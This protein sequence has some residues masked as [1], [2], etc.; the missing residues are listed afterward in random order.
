VVEEW[1][2]PDDRIQA[3]LA[4]CRLVLGGT[5]K[6]LPNKETSKLRFSPKT[7]H[8]PACKKNESRGGRY[9]RDRG[10]PSYAIFPTEYKVHASSLSAIEHSNRN[11]LNV[12]VLRMS[13]CRMLQLKLEAVEQ[14]T[15][16][17]SWKER[18]TINASLHFL[19]SVV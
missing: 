2:R 1:A 16:N 19:C 9:F 17:P 12:G 15:W 13:S 7:S 14:L 8:S 18:C 6:F 10:I 11:K 5:C 3:Q 4:A